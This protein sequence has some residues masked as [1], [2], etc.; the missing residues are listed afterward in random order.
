MRINK[1]GFIGLGKMGKAMVLHLLEKGIDV[2][3]YNRTQNKTDELSS[4]IKNLK[5]KIKNSGRLNKSYELVELVKL[6]ERPRII[7]LMVPHGPP[8]DEMISKLLG[9]GVEKGDIVIDGGNSF[10]KDSIRRYKLLKEKGINYLD[11]GTSGGL[12][13]A[14]NGSCMMV[15][16]DENIF[17]K[18]EPI[19]KL[20]ATPDGVAYFGQSGAGHFVKMVH[21][22][23]EYGMLQSIGEGFEMLER[24]PY[25]L[26]LHKVAINYTK[27]SVVRGWLM[28]LL[29]RA[30]KTDPNLS[31][32]TGAIGGGTTGEWAVNT[33]RE[34]KVSVP[35]FQK[36]L[37]ERKKSFA[38]PTFSGKVIAALRRE[39]GGHPIQHLPRAGGLQPRAREER[40]YGASE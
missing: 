34:L 1:L 26:D 19:L 21:N 2:V 28:E 40:V 39:F 37:E 24:G 11:V 10:Y 12:E 13:G 35:V 14:R 32:I 27:G 31:N 4:E 16:G 7:W 18:V 5:L 17:K 20:A 3:V 36:S 15:G 23:I 6:L 25:K 22:G 8:V 38:K 33:A 9:W 29:E 30:L